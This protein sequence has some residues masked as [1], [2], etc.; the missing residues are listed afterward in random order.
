MTILDA[1]VLGLV[2][3]ITEFLPISSTGHL[4]LTAHFLGLDDA[5]EKAAMDAFNIVLQGG[6]IL[7]VASVYWPRVR[8]MVMGVLGQD[9]AGF[10]LLVKLFV[11][12]LPAGV[13]GLLLNKW[14]EKHLFF[15]V[16]VIAAVIV[17]GLFMLWLDQWRSGRFGAQDRLYEHRKIEDLSLVQCLFIGCM[18][19]IAM[20]PG[21]SRSMMGIAGGMF[22]GLRTRDA[23]EFAFLLGLPTLGGATLYK[24]YK[25]VSGPAEENMF[26]VF[27][28]P[29]IVVGLVVAFVSA[30]LAVRWLVGFLNKHG[31]SLFGWYRLGL[32]AVMIVAAWRGWVSISPT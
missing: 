17:G 32:G 28:T 31:L 21:T 16:P 10:S 9:N 29:A 23:A 4:I 24:L 11:A 18:Q 30:F 25:N 8:Q 5:R 26:K 6:T 27:S 2:E 19:C 22:C 12:F 1:V 3:G 20:W 7:A 15:P 13:F 14:L